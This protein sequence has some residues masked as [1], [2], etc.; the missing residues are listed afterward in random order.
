MD[1]FVVLDIVK[2]GGG[3]NQAKL[4]FVEKKRDQHY[5]A[6]KKGVRGRGKGLGCELGAEPIPLGQFSFQPTK[7]GGQR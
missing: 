4:L 6:T 5:R 2:G 1:G 7:K 3:G